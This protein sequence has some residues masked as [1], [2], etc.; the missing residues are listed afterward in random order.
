VE[1]P[2]FPRCTDPDDQ[3]FIS[4]GLYTGAR[5]L[6]SRDRAVLRCA[7]GARALGLEILT[8]SAW[9]AR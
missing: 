5:A 9:A 3:K 7:R 1:P 2:G 4:L 8:P 6:L